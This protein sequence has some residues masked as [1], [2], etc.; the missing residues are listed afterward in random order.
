[1]AVVAVTDHVFPDLDQEREILARAG[2]EL[3]FERNAVSVEE[4]TVAVAGADAV[5]NC[6]SKMPGDVIRTLDSCRIIARYGIGVDTIDLDAANERGIVVTNVPD[7][8]IDEVSDHALSLALALARGVT[9]LDRRVRT[10]SWTPTDARPLHRIRGRT[11]GLVGF[12]RIARA[13]AVKAAALGY[14]VVATDPYIADDAVRDA[15]V[16]PLSFDELLERADVVSMHVPLTDESHHLFG[17]EALAKMKSGAILVNTSR[18]PLVDTAALRDALASG[19]LGGA[20][21]DVLEQEPPA[22]DEPLLQRDDVVIT[23]HA[24]FYS[25]ESVRELQRKA[26]EQVVDALA[27]RRPTYALNADVVGFGT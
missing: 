2:H 5:L 22:P 14:H 26:V 24:G 6:Y 11:L 18:G 27:G 25:E 16:E 12:G 9:L 8:C 15:G 1:M 17:S 21:L 10:G 20:A 23:P 3:R 13:L 19:H 4:V 7:Y